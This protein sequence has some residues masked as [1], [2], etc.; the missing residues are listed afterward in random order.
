M[1]LRWW[2]ESADAA[3]E[4]AALT[5]VMPALLTFSSEA[6][7]KL[8]FEGELYMPISLSLAAFDGMCE[9]DD[10]LASL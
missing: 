5:G 3:F 9:S 1:I 8:A 7:R 4:R 10:R 2:V 6:R